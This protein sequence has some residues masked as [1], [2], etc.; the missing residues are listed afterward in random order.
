[1]ALVRARAS[2]ISTANGFDEVIGPADILDDRHPHVRARPDMFVA[3][4]PTIPLPQG[5]EETT[6]VPGERRGTRK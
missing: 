1:M 3:V 5:V 2:F 4:A 6:A